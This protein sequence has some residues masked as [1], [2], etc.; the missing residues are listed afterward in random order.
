MRWQ[1]PVARVAEADLT[2]RE[3]GTVERYLAD[4]EFGVAEASCASRE[5]GTEERDA[6]LLIA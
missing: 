1:P 2:A 3:L 4:G 5:H 6:A